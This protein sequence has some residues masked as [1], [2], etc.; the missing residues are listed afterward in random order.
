MQEIEIAA[1]IGLSDVIQI[2]GREA[3]FVFTLRWRPVG[4]PLRGGIAALAP[5]LFNS[6]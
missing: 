2:Q 5:C 6:S 3:A 1:L 4:A